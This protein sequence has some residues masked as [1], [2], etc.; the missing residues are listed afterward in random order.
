MPPPGGGLLSCRPLAVGCCRAAPWRWA[1]VVPPPGG[2]LLSCRPLAVQAGVG[3]A[4]LVWPLWLTWAVERRLRMQ[5]AA[6]CAAWGQ[7]QG[8]GQEQGQGV[9]EQGYA[10][11]QQPQ[12]SG[13][14]QQ[15]AG[16]ASGVQLL[17][18]APYRALTTSSFMSVKLRCCAQA[19]R[20]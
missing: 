13:I 15:E 9:Q 11:Q 14:C 18:R 4:M 10:K 6:L 19:H 8:Q 20:S 12:F 17:S 16:G 1:A 3:L 5:H 7:R 2:G